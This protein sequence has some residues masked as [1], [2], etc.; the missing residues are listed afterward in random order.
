MRAI[1]A[2]NML[3]PQ[4][5]LLV[6]HLAK[7]KCL[8]R[9]YRPLLKKLGLVLVGSMYLIQCP[10]FRVRRRRIQAHNLARHQTRTGGNI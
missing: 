10:G 2:Y 1:D 3:A 8:F 5:M 6:A 7:M 9:Q 4:Y